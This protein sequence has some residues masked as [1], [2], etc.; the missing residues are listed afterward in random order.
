MIF[1]GVSL[2]EGATI[3]N[4]TVDSGTS[5]P[6]DPTTGELFFRTDSDKLF[7]YDGATWIETGTG[8][9]SGGTGSGGPED[10]VFYLNDTVVTSNYTVP[11]SKNAMTAG[12]VTIANG[13]TVTVSNGSTWA[14]V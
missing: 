9:S 10:G 13:V 14:V 12:P 2:A 11:V 7:V 5:F 1:H 4:A 8:G 6:T 3:K